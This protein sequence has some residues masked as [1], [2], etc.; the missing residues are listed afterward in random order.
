MRRAL[1]GGIMGMG[2][3]DSGQ[4]GECMPKIVGGCLCGSVRY[5]SEAEPVL[6]AACHCHHCQKQTSSAFSIFVVLPKGS[7]TIEGEPLAA[8]EDVGDSG[9]P[10]FRKF[11]SKCGSAIVSEVVATPDLEWLNAG[12]LDDPSWFRPQMN[13]WCDSAQPWVSIDDDI[14]AYA[15]NPPQGD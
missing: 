6:T 12:T 15:G 14:P 1:G 11:C 13:L 2:E 10:V 8:F 3:R 4:G 5:Q 9:L 7:L